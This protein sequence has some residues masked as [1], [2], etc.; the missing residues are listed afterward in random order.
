MILRSEGSLKLEMLS[1]ARTSKHVDNTTCVKHQQER[2][3]QLRLKG[4]IKLDSDSVVII[5]YPC[6]LIDKI[7]PIRN[8][9]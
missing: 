7:V 2:G 9:L 6:F 5:S 3:G 4:V 8:R 1:H